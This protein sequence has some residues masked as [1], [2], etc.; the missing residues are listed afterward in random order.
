MIADRKAAGLDR[1]TA[2]GLGATGPAHNLFANGAKVRRFEDL[3][4]DFHALLEALSQDR[5]RSNCHARRKALGGG[6]IEGGID[7]GIRLADPLNTIKTELTSTGK[8]EQEEFAFDDRSKTASI[9]ANQ[10]FIQKNLL[11]SI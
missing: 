10:Q 5:G 7:A 2:L 8:H 1:R 11:K 3:P 6:L 9:F 4:A